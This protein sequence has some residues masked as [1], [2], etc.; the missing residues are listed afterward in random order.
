MVTYLS[1]L[2]A[3]LVGCYLRKKKHRLA[4]KLNF[5]LTREKEK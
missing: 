3:F 5:E 1:I 2:V 4:I